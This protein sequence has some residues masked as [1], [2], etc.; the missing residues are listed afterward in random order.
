MSL[1]TRL[2]SAFQAVG[3]D[4]KALKAS[5]LRA[6][7]P[8]GTT[9]AYATNDV[10][11][12]TGSSY[13][14]KVDVVASATTPDA[15]PASW[16]VLAAKGSAGPTGPAGLT[17]K[18]PY[19]VAAG[20]YILN[21]VVTRNGSA[22]RALG[23][24]NTT[25]TPTVGFD[26]VSSGYQDF[27]TSLT[28]THIPVGTPRGVAVAIS[29]NDAA[30]R[31]TGVTYG[32]V[33]MTRVQQNGSGSAGNAIY[34]LGSGVPT[35][36]QSVVVS[37]SSNTGFAAFVTTVTTSKGNTAS[38]ATAQSNGDIAI[39]PSLTLATA[40]DFQG[41]VL[42]CI[43]NSGNEP[44]TGYTKI[45]QTNHTGEYGMKSGAAV[46]ADWV[47]GSNFQYL[48]A[49]AIGAAPVGDGFDT[50][51]WEAFVVKGDTGIPGAAST[52]PGPPGLTARGAFSVT[53]A[54]A[55]ND[56]VTYSGST[57][58]AMVAVPA[59]ATTPDAAPT[60]WEV[61]AAKGAAGAVGVGGVMIWR[62][63][64]D[65]GVTPRSEY[66]VTISDTNVKTTTKILAQQAYDAV[67]GKNVDEQ[68]MD[69]FDVIGFAGTGQITFNIKFKHG[70][71][72]GAVPI[73]YLLS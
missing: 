23:T 63:E 6:K 46:V 60:S 5:G 7:G 17:P 2:T 53:T 25:G 21:D 66:L 20:S 24:I 42:S 34:F 37:A 27:G 19:N 38:K 48:A 71:A 55:T 54:Y 59:S 72:T 11:T 49:I 12:H 14:A 18:G 41:L 29:V 58:R 69:P 13:R 50:S 65:L 52:V 40:S 8:F 45:T 67:T 33:A 1:E 43:R 9:T 35:G 30:D 32:G 31:I 16:E 4:V 47:A 64:I 44:G 68:E 70:P 39:N 62:A 15:A 73:N 57:Y 36:S 51:E 10:V 28:I 61:L 56:V 26:A 3:A 22:H